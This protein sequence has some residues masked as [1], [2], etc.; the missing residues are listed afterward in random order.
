MCQFEYSKH[1]Q[2][3]RHFFGAGRY[4]QGARPEFLRNSF[5][6]SRLTYGISNSRMLSSLNLSSTSDSCLREN[7]FWYFKRKNLSNLYILFDFEF[8]LQKMVEKQT[9]CQ[10]QVI[11]IK[12]SFHI[13][14]CKH[15]AVLMIQCHLSWFSSG[16]LYSHPLNFLLV[17]KNLQLI[18]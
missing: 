5:K 9:C 6:P 2:R 1:R 18:M 3:L 17:Y 14:S 10:N 13:Q 15:M 7:S 8:H 16:D 4:K 11:I 12:F